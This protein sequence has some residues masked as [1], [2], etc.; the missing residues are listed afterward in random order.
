M[1]PPS[2]FRGSLKPAENRSTVE[3]SGRRERIT[4]GRKRGLNAAQ[5]SVTEP[6]DQLRT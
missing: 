1:T 2:D 4:S 6:F 3:E 5:R